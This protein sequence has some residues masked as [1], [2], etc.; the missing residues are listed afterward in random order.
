MAE[1]RQR[2]KRHRPNAPGDGSV[3][4][5]RAGESGHINIHQIDREDSM[6]TITMLAL[7]LGTLLTAGCGGGGGGA[8]A[9]APAQPTATVAITSSNQGAV[10]RATIDGSQA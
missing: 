9:D 2:E 5:R 1:Q 6:R 7:A 4:T 8:G 10:A 3:A